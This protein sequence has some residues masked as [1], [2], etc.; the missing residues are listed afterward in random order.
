MHLFESIFIFLKQ[1]VWVALFFDSIFTTTGLL[2][3]GLIPRV[4]VLDV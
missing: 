1:C 3:R 4:V 2:T